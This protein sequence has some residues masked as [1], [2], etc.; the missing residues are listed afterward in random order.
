KR[1]PKMWEP[2]SDLE[3]NFNDYLKS[4][5]VDPETGGGWKEE[6]PDSDSEKAE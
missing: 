1:E 5:G 6:E 4:K 2:D 3:I